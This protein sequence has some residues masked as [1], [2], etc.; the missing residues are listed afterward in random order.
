MLRLFMCHQFGRFAFFA[1]ALELHAEGS[2]AD[3][4]GAGG[5]NT[6]ALELLERA[7]NHLFFD[8]GERAAG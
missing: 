5:P 1:P 2:H 4:Q 7:E 3:S 6:M 8:V